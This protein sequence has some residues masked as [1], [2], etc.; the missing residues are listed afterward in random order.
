MPAEAGTPTTRYESPHSTDI[1]GEDSALA[2]TYFLPC[3]CGG[4]IPVQARQAGQTV[5]CQCGRAVDAPTMLGLKALEQ[6]ELEPETRPW[7]T[8]Q[9]LTVLGIL[10][11]SISVVGAAYTLWNRPHSPIESRP[12]ERVNEQVQALSAAETIGLWRT[13]ERGLDRGLVR[14]M[15]VYHGAL[16][17]YR[18]CLLLWGVCATVGGGLLIAGHKIS[19]RQLDSPQ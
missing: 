10:V 1:P 16:G 5:R 7:G 12:P 4:K 18:L 14:E 8:S 17:T 9:R 2:V 11:L 19:N 15:D 13:L 6:V 3:S